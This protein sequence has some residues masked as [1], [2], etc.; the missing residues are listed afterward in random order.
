MSDKKQ[1]AEK[2]VLMV[3]GQDRSGDL[4]QDIGAEANALDNAGLRERISGESRILDLRSAENENEFVDSQLKIFGVRTQLD[5]GEC[6]LPEKSSAGVVG[7]IIGAVRGF[8]WR[9][10]KF[11]FGWIVFHQNVINEQQ[12]ITLAHEV[13][14]RKRENRELLERIELLE[15]RIKPT[16]EVSS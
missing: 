16:E 6:E 5:L 3:A 4:G 13:R 10:L 1:I 7:R 11:A 9:L 15:S 8:V 14:L 2:M 12:A